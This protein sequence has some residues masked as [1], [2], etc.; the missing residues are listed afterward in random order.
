MEDFSGMLL[1][2]FFGYYPYELLMFL[3]CDKF[4]SDE[5]C[6]VILAKLKEN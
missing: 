4:Y 5:N 6:F 1:K 3:S 2:Y